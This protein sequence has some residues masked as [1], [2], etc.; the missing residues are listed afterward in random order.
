MRLFAPFILLTQFTAAQFPEYI[1]DQDEFSYIDYYMDEDY[2]TLPDD[3]L[4][5]ME[6]GKKNKYSNAKL[7]QGWVNI[8][9]QKYLKVGDNRDRVADVLL[10][11]LNNAPDSGK[12]PSYGQ[13][14]QYGCWCQLFTQL[15]HTSNKGTPIDHID[16]ACRSWSKCVECQV[17]DNQK[18]RGVK[19]TYGKLAYNSH[20]DEL[21]CEYAANPGSCARTACECDLRLA[22]SL[23]EFSYDFQKSNM[24]SQGFDPTTQCKASGQG[25]GQAAV[26]DQC[27][28]STPTRFPF[29]S[30][31]GNR[32]CCNG[33]TYNAAALVCCSHGPAVTC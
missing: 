14:L 15:W 24:A 26:V 8:P 18:C 29:Y 33:K 22:Q 11:L 7:P 23:Y 17:M 32:A 31:N 2:E 1:N 27:C 16:A 4:I 20:L 3:A 21:S 6:R 13:L 9:R 10:Y 30:D 12:L 28:G 5:G 25:E 19:D